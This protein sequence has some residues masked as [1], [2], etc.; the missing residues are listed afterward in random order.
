LW[1]A[2]QEVVNMVNTSGNKELATFALGA[3]IGAGIAGPKG[4]FI[5]GVIGFIIGYNKK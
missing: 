4:A 5:G 3:L 1:D 2:A